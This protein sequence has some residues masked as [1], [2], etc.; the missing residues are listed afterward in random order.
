[1]K[2]ILILSLL[3]STAFAG[4][5][6]KNGNFYIS[7]TD[8]VVPGGG[9]KLDITRTYNSKSTSEGWF[10]FGW[11]NVYETV[12]VPSPDGCVVVHEHGA[13]GKTRFCPKNKVDPV[14]AA[15]KIITA[16]KK[17]SKN[18]LTGSAQKVLLKRLTENADLRHAYAKNFGIQTK[19]ATGTQLFSNQRGI[20][21]IKVTKNGYLRKSNDGKKEYF[22]KL[23]N[24]TKI[25]EKSGYS[26]EFSYKNKQL[27]SV[28]D[29]QA[30]QIFFSWYSNGYVKELWS[31][32]DKKAFFKYKGRNLV[33]SRDVGG[34]EYAFSYDKSHNLTKIV[35][36]PSRKKGEP[37]D[38][39]KMEYEK[40]TLFISKITDR[41][42][43]VV[44]YKYGADAKRPNDHYWTLVTKN[45]FNGKPVTNRYEYE[46][47]VKPD[48]ARYT[49]RILT[50]INSIKTETIY[51]ECCGLPLK[52]ARGKHVTTFDY[53]EKGQMVKKTSTKGEFVYIKYDD[54]INKIKEVKNNQG[55]TK[56][57]YD[58]KGNLTK[59]LNSENQAVLLVY[60]RKGKITKMVDNNLKTKKRRIL[61]F[62]YNAS[63]K[64]TEISMAK[65]G[66]INV[67]YDNYGE[68]K[69]VDSKAGHKMALQVTQAF[70]NLLTIVKPAG[71]NLNM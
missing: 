61:S 55:W 45:G 16:M 53:N 44:S 7:Y 48:G 28:K 21:S 32:G 65:V 31:A 27:F 50:E 19:I 17:K 15:N 12:L 59:A 67:A 41:N 68:I 2:K 63:G 13:G 56:F 29:S 71:V 23:G 18:P 40:K 26:V 54:K 69:R 6:L 24:L 43:E 25:K 30:K 36:N 39:M 70:Q 10:G 4:V 62:K 60:D 46:I 51:S 49:Y 38:S 66:K 9:K 58:K 14:A 33:Y 34:N 64:P 1:M 3:I 5:N 22:D 52:I 11:G 20:Q 47:K 37:E 35:Y 57:T 42:G 8:I